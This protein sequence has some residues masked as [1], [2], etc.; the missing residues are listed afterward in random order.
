MKKKPK[1]VDDDSYEKIFSE[2][3]DSFDLDP[4]D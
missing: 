4:K 3:F 2:F 1:Y